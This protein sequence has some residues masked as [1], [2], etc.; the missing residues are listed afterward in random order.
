M[1]RFSHPI[2]E[3]GGAGRAVKPMGDSCGSDIVRS[4]G[5]RA[6]E[7]GS[8]AST[9]CLPA[10]FHWTKKGEAGSNENRST[11]WVAACPKRDCHALRRRHLDMRFE[12]PKNKFKRIDLRPDIAAQPTT[13]DT[14]KHF[15]PVRA[16]HDAHD[17]LVPSIFASTPGRRFTW[18]A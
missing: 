11:T 16:N 9:C 7:F 13:C 6:P 5:F 12:Q 4:E 8:N 17:R 2:E 3:K 18:G 10:P 14:I 1:S 15:Q